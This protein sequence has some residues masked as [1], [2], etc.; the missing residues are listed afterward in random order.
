MSVIGYIRVSTDQQVDSGLSL[1]A[2][3]MK[4]KAYAIARELPVPFMV[5]DAG[6]SAKNLNR[7]GMQVIL[8][9]IDKQRVSAV[10]VSKLDRLTRNVRD[11]GYLLEL[12]QKHNVALMSVSDSLD[13]SSA[14]GRLCLNMMMSVAQWEREIIS[15][16]TKDGLAAKRKRGEKL[17]GK[18]PYGFKVVD[19]KLV[20]DDREQEN[21]RI[22]NDL[23]QQGI[24]QRDIACHLNE[25][26]RTTREG[27]DWRHQ[28]VAR[29][30][31]RWPYVN[32]TASS[33]S[34]CVESAPAHGGTSL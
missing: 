1:E 7:Q 22:I 23:A 12:F 32:E 9:E 28:Y 30:I 17:G 14:T 20:E 29:I 2:Q 13:T 10:I 26:G 16:R 31:K 5:M 15:E 18:V 19:G 24:S 4:I 21:I 25:R 33:S 27:G 34:P 8:K 6:Y 3:E 11:L